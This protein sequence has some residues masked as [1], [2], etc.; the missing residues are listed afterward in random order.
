MSRLTCLF[1]IVVTFSTPL[2]TTA[3]DKVPPPTV[4]VAEGE[5]FQTKGES[6]WQ[7]RHQD[8]TYATQTFGAMWVTHGGLLAAP[9]SSV[10]DVAIQRVTI[11]ADGK[12]RVWSKYQSPPYFNY[13]HRV[14]V[15]QNNRKVFSHDYGKIGAERIYSFFGKTVYGLPPKKQVWFS[16][17]VDHDAAEAPRGSVALRK[18]AAE[19]RLISLD[20]PAPAGDRF[21]DFVLLT[22]NHED[23][24]I[25]WEKHGQAKSPFMFEAIHSTPI[26]FRFKNVARAPAKARLFTHF[27]HFTWHCAPKR[28]LVPDKAVAAGQ[29]SPW[30][31]INRIVEL[32]TDEGLQVTLIDGASEGR[33]AQQAPGLV[34]GNVNVPVEFALDSS[35]RNPI[36]SLNVPNGETIHVPI[37]I[38]WNKQKK[39]RLSKDISAE[40]VKLSKTS[41]WRKASP[42]KPKHIA[43]YGS[44]SRGDNPWAMTLKDAL[45]YNTLLPAGKQ[46]LEVDGYF[47]HLRNPQSIQQFAETLGDKRKN[48]RVCSFGDE[49]SLGRINFADPKYIE[50]FRAWLK[51]KKLTAAE[52]RMPLEKATLD[53]NNRL[54]WYANLFSAEQRFAHYRSLTATARKAFGPQVLTGAN[55]SPHHDVMYYGNHLQWIDAFKHRAMS[56]FWTEDYIFMVPELPQTMSFLMARAQCAV[57]Y[58]RQPIHMYVMPHQPGQPAEYFR[59]NTLLSIG[60]GAKHIDNFWVGPQENYSEN[61]VS[62]QYP[63]TFQAIFEAMHD[64]AAVESLLV[65]SRPRP[66]RIAVITGKSTALNEDMVEVKVQDDKFLR[67]SH[68]A[69]KVHQNICRKDQQ[70]LYFALRHAQHGVDLITEDDIIELNTLRKYDVVYFAGEWINP[71]AVEKMDAWVQAGGILY[72]ST[73]L[74]VKNQYNEPEQSLLKLLGLRQ[75]TLSK[76]LYH[77]R[78]LLELP[79]TDPIDT[80]TIGDQ[81]ISAIA[82]KQELTPVS[83]DIEIIGRWSNNKPAV[84]VR[85]HGKGKAIAVG[86]AAGATYLKT[87]TRPIPWARGGKYNLYNPDEFDEAATK[88]I[89]LGIDA[90]EVKRQV[91]CSEPLVESFVLDNKKGSLLTLV[92]WTNQQTIA[93]LAVEIQV[94]SQPK[95]V[96]SITTQKELAAEYDKGR[97]KFTLEL[98]AADYVMIEY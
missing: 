21:V 14:E 60:A 48:F 41:Q 24:C 47:Q 8:D 55:Y 23:T 70:F 18:G 64:T 42:T 12:F 54:K 3:Q 65:D 97:L 52:I 16:W 93:E 91:T 28:G 68:I 30:V 72:A 66:A 1:A 56:M 45:G 61:Y 32:V 82:F 63:Q 37:D 10:N 89:R 74:G 81:K 19:I 86:T 7:V 49:I 31:N 46:T 51:Q 90:K 20:S 35:G 15:W 62:W 11:P 17:G 69:G 77:V 98:T 5:R 76:N 71:K 79:L 92:N 58:H 26:Y 88:F 39:L 67:M 53:G 25:G 87:G 75:A 13:A 57:K 44:F 94:R 36:G 4:V 9:A 34:G 80:I 33:A 22:T 6:G 50:P 29:W 73:G 40:L 78:P 43:F 59:R 38:T 83:D 85:T 96:F 27:G 2:V 84:T 95:R